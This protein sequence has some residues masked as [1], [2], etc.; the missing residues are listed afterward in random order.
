MSIGGRATS[1]HGAVARLRTAAPATAVAGRVGRMERIFAASLLLAGLVMR[2]LAV[3]RHRV[4]SDEPQHLHVAW[5]WTQGLLPYRDVFDN[6]SPLF[7]LVMSWPL[8][9]LGE[10]PD[11]VIA[12]R[13]WML[14]FA[15]GAMAFTWI[16][17]RR[18]LGPRA[19]L[20]SVALLGLDCDFLL[21]SVEYRT[22]VPWACVWLAT[23]AV[24]VCGRLTRRRA[25]AAG[26]LAGTA[27]AISMKTSLLVTTAVAG[28]VLAWLASRGSERPSLA[29]TGSLAAAAGAGF[30]VVPLVVVGWFASQGALEPMIRC[31]VGYNVV[32]GLGLWGRA[33]LRPLGLLLGAPLVGALAVWA[34]RHVASAA[35]ARRSVALFAG[36]GFAH[37]AIETLWPLVVRGDMLPLRPVESIFLVAVLGILV[38]RATTAMPALRTRLPGTVLALAALGAIVNTVRIADLGH[39]CSRSERAALAGVLHLTRP[40]DLVMSVKGEAVFRR[41]S[42][43][44]AIETIA[45]ERYRQGQLVDDIPERLAATGTAVVMQYDTKPYPARAWRFI[46]ANYLPVCDVRVLGQY[47]DPPPTGPDE[48]RFTVAVPQSYALFGS[49]RPAQG[50]LDGEP[51]R[52]PRRLGAGPHVYVAAAGEGRLALVWAPAV[53]RG[54]APALLPGPPLTMSAAD[55][56]LVLAPHPDDEIV[57]NAGLIQ[58]ARAAGATVWI[59][60]ATDG[61]QNPWAQLVHEGRWPT[62]AADHAHWGA[63]RRGESRRALESLGAADAG[64][65]WLGFPD[66]GLTRQWMSGDERLAD[67]LEQIVR[68]FRPTIVSAPSMF[69]DHPDHN[70]MAL[71]A[72]VALS[73]V[74]D[75]ATRPR[76]VTYLAHRDEL[77]PD[78]TLRLS[79]ST[80]ERERKLHAIDCLSSQ[81]HW[82]RREFTALADT[83]ECFGPPDSLAAGRPPHRV[84]G[85]WIRGNDLVVYFSS[86][87]RF[88]LG[89]STLRISCDG[90]SGPLARITLPVPERAGE[91]AA[92]AGSGLDAAQRVQL[93]RVRDEWRAVVP[94]DVAQRPLRVFVK[95][96]R[97]DELAMGFFDESGWWPVPA[98][99]PRP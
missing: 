84:Q 74:P 5:A 87:R 31:T 32:P 75:P 82:R 61:E 66:G 73:R 57:S 64:Q 7:S 43:Y 54:Y 47:L 70:L 30:V 90:A 25:F 28:A 4:N 3:L 2:G 85:A 60:W 11:I 67:S 24:M 99:A 38:S 79:L 36:T 71:A 58:A 18:L 21:G 88:H 13:M 97:P 19:A 40:G 96:E 49:E 44:T 34:G 26:L 33:P 46:Q 45:E 10:R 50:V 56:L 62:S 6:H 80:A 69:D 12:M 92:P 41:R 51:W 37:L 55:R 9:A 16:I 15:L 93:S 77:A 48:R 81:L 23:V 14:P 1:F 27:L 78:P 76:L 22:D 39:D 68:E 17:A 72:V 89:P 63:L 98:S 95:L 94:L 91:I 42:V 52:G 8:R 83:V 35:D 65:S 29:R 59:V 20:W 86:G 53:E